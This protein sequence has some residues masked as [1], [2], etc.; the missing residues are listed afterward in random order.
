MADST[1]DLDYVRAQFPGLD[2]PWVLAD[3]AGGSVP[4]RRVCDRIAAYLREDMVQLGASYDRSRVAAE[5]VA[6]GRAAAARLVGGGEDEIVLGASTTSNIQLLANA[7]EP[8]LSPGD[9]VVVSAL[10]HESNVGPW[11]RLASRGVVV[12]IWDFDPADPVLTM[13]GL[14]A[15]LS[16]RTKVVAFCQV[17]NVVGSIHP[18]ADFC[19]RIRAA[20]AISVVDGVAYA[21]HRHVDVES[22]GCDVYVQSLYKVYGPH[23]SLMWLAPRVWERVASQNHFF[24]GNDARPGILQPGSVNHELCAGLPGII[25]YLEGLEEHHR[26]RE[27]ADMAERRTQTLADPFRRIAAHEEKLTERLIEGLLGIDGVALIGSSDPGRAHRVPTV[28][29]T[30]QNRLA[31]ELPPLL[32]PKGLAIRWGHFYA[33]RA[34]E[35]M[36]LLQRDG[37]VRVSLV[38]YNRLD[39][40]DRI[41]EAL[42]AAIGG[43]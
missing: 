42:S 43:S 1:L 32:D 25:E 18:V 3:N 10:D 15:V 4:A 29:F 24:L 35:R 30:V 13:A 12:K 37:V 9:E 8:G 28:A 40:V 33:Y 14:E 23:Q 2:S 7:L 41:V 6:A 22:L 26:A 21:P 17:S 19:E 5:R 11:T 20:N 34:I 16:P 27:G 31:S 38:H 39:E 36:Q